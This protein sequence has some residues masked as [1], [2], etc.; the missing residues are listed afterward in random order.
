[1][2]SGGQSSSAVRV[3]RQTQALSTG[4]AA[5]AC[6]ETGVSPSEEVADGYNNRR[7]ADTGDI[8]HDIQRGLAFVARVSTG[9]LG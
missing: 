6:P 1:M 5:N 2:D 7:L 8:P 4:V 3:A 9:S